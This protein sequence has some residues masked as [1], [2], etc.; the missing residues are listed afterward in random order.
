MTSIK[1][2]WNLFQTEWDGFFRAIKNGFFKGKKQFSDQY[3]VKK[4][5]FYTA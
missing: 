5:E 2:R 3:A 1:K 4:N